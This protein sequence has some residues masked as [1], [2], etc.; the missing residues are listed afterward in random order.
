MRGSQKGAVLSALLVAA[1]DA[2]VT[3]QMYQNIEEEE[4]E[5]NLSLQ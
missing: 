1:R 4:E 3:V 5:G 2:A